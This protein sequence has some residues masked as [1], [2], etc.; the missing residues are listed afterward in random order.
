M[1]RK[2]T[3]HYSFDMCCF[4]AYLMQDLGVINL[5]QCWFITASVMNLEIGDDE[6][7]LPK[8][9]QKNTTHI[10]AQ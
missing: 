8:W 5:S 2:H 7:L 3:E 4:F 6:E 10:A 9:L 1:I